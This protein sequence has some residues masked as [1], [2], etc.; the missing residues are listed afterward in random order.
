MYHHTIV[1]HI[2]LNESFIHCDRA[3]LWQ[4]IVGWTLKLLQS[5]CV[6]TQCAKHTKLAHP[7]ACNLGVLFEHKYQ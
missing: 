1:K 5:V 3:G 4:N 7:G 2:K 6:Q